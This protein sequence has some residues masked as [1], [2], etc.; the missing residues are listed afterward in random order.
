LLTL[1]PCKEVVTIVSASLDRRLTWREQLVMRLHLVAC[2]P[3]ERYLKQSH[4]LS[5]AASQM[6]DQLKDELFTGKLSD[7]ARERIKNMLR[8]TAGLF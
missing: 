3:C 4:F 2:R 1:P 5:I 6:E 7:D 8:T